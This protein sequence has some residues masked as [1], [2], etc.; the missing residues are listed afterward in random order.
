M[1]AKITLIGPPQGLRIEKDIATFKLITGPA[2]STAPKG[3]PIFKAT[4][5]LVQCSQKQY[6]KA[7]ANE[8][9]KSE[10]IIEGY[11]EPRLDEQGK[12]YVAV[13]AVSVISKQAQ[14]ERKLA[15]IR[16]EV[17]KAEEA[18]EAAC[19]RHGLESAQAKAALELMEK[20]KANLVKF[21]GSHPELQ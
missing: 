12:L 20:V 1:T 13:V 19:D 16:D 21:L 11:Q 15:Q 6:R 8:Q 10:L 9:D 4:T 14:A 7:R 5:Y 2:S 17:V 18:Y 3:L